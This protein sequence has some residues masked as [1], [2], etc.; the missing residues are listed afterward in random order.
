MTWRVLN[1]ATINGKKYALFGS[2]N[3]T[4]PYQGDTDSNEVRSLLCIQKKNLPAPSG[5]PP[6]TTTNGGALRGSWSGGRVLIV[7]EIQAGTLTSQLLADE[8]C[9]LQGLRGVGEHTSLFRLD[10]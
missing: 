3:L 1:T 4:N 7:P 8:K 6:S 10:F 5:L 9:R 2:D